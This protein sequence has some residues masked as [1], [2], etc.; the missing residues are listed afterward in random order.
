MWSL[1][2]Q[3]TEIPHME[4]GLETSLHYFVAL[5]TGWTVSMETF[6]NSVTQSCH[7]RTSKGY[8]WIYNRRN[9]SEQL[10]ISFICLKLIKFEERY[11]LLFLSETQY[12]IYG[13]SFSVLTLWCYNK[14][15]GVTAR[16]RPFLTAESGT[17]TSHT[18]KFT[19]VEAIL[20]Q[21][22]LPMRQTPHAGVLTSVQSTSQQT[23]L[24]WKMLNIISECQEISPPRASLC[25]FEEI[26]I[27]FG[28]EEDILR[29]SLLH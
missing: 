22:Q 25:V 15:D 19:A 2:T 17:A 12:I 23:A 20:I 24:P 16:L 21:I 27:G 28:P 8:L 5:L 1:A 14:C 4:Q 26:C 29:T 3:L 11:R 13:S 7:V 9:L 18:N 10:I 6:K